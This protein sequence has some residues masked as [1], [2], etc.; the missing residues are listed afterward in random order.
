MQSA[1]RLF[2]P[3]IAW[4]DTTGPSALNVTRTTTTPC[5]WVR[6]AASGYKMSSKEKGLICSSRTVASCCP[7]TTQTARQQVAIK[8]MTSLGPAAKCHIA[9]LYPVTG[10]RT[11]SCLVL[12]CR[13]YRMTD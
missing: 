13:R 5:T 9:V 3:E 10:A 1:M 8:A 4:D 12:H 2:A 11:Q 7:E 6:R